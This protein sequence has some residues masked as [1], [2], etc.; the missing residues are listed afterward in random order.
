M[1][2]SLAEIGAYIGSALA[3]GWIW[4]PIAG[5]M[6]AYQRTAKPL[7]A[8]IGAGLGIILWLVITLA[9]ALTISAY[10]PSSSGA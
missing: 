5:A 6:I 3:T 7:N 9:I 4:M 10:A 2:G 8:A 1:D